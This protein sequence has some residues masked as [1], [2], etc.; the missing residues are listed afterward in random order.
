MAS[1][2]VC[3]LLLVLMAALY[4]W[5]LGDTPTYLSPDE[6]IIS[7]DAH[8]LATTGRDV[9]G[10]LLPLYF[11]IHQPKSERSGWF[12]PVIFYLSAAVQMV[13]PFS[14]ATIRVPSVLIGLAGLVLLFML[15]RV[16]FGSAW[17]ALMTAAMLAL[18]PAYYI[19]SRYGLDYLYPV[20]FLVA[21]AMAL[22]RAIQLPSP[23]HLLMCGLCLGIAFYSYAAAVLLTPLLVL[24]SIA[25]LWPSCGRP[26]RAAFVAV[27]YALPLFAI[28]GSHCWRRSTTSS[29][30]D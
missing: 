13:L 18:S 28:H 14:E 5:R 24:V 26:S 23:R 4:V 20:P 12:T 16:V 3:G 30:C 22:H 7:V 21:W 2:A 25:T 8:A 9:H 6:A 1:R 10:T 11:Y 15:A 29:S 27:G 17:L 19:F